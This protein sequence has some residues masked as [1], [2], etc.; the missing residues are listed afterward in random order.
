MPDLDREARDRALKKADKAKKK[1]R[2]FNYME[3]KGRFG[4]CS[5]KCKC[6][7][8]LCEL[9]PVPEMQEIQRT[10][11]QTIIRERIAMFTNS[12]YNEIEITFADGSKHITMACGSCIQKGFEPG[13]LDNIYAADMA[14]WADEEKRGMGKVHW[15]MNADREAVSWRRIPSEERFRD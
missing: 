4:V 15:A 7:Q 3:E 5:V 11:G 10:K 6:G 12:A 14:R 8:T 2:G 13:D 1:L 9:Q